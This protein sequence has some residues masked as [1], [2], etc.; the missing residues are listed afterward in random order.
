M[1]P[2]QQHEG[3]VERLEYYVTLCK[4]WLNSLRAHNRILQGLFTCQPGPASLK[5]SHTVL[6][7]FPTPRFFCTFGCTPWILASNMIHF[8]SPISCLNC[9]KA[10]IQYLA[11]A[12][13]NFEGLSCLQS[14]L[15]PYH[16]VEYR[17][18]HTPSLQSLWNNVLVLTKIEWFLGTF[19]EYIQ[20]MCNKVSSCWQ[21]NK[22][23]IYWMVN[24]WANVL[25]ASA[26]PFPQKCSYQ[27]AQTLYSILTFLSQLNQRG[28]LFCSTV[29]IQSINKTHYDLPPP[30]P[31]MLP[32]PLPS[33][34]FS[35]WWCSSMGGWADAITQCRG[36]PHCTLG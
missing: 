32:K 1:L 26:F 18:S 22:Q 23:I 30:H 33:C 29:Y 3:C 2:Q 7:A 11:N 17:S 12:E 21:L 15:P 24:V 28:N 36:S 25:P 19:W 10:R 4:P 34:P 8:H 14:P 6:C 13:I 27:A 20:L 9:K 35:R 5:S 16:P 31:N